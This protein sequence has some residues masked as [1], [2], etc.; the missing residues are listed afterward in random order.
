MKQ[1]I[2]F[3]KI[4][5]IKFD[6]IVIPRNV[7]RLHVDAKISAGCVFFTFLLKFPFELHTTAITINSLHVQLH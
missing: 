5:S 1:K 7:L 3:K 4:R 6:L 2:I